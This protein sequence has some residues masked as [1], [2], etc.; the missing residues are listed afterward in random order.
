M[1]DNLVHA[2]S[3]ALGGICSTIATYPLLTITIRQ[4]VKKD[5]DVKKSFIK[6]LTET[7]KE[8][9]FLD[10]YSG[11]STSIFG[12]AVTNGIYSYWYEL[13]KSNLKKV[14][15]HEAMTT[16]ES[17]LSGA[18][19]G[20]A[21][22]LTTNP[23][24]L[25]N[26]RCSAKVTLEN[27]ADPSKVKGIG[28]IEMFKKIVK[29]EGFFS[30]WNGITPALILVINPIIQYTAFEQLKN[31]TIKH[32]GKLNAL[33]IFILG[34]LGKLVAT[35]VTYPYTLIKSRMQLRQGERDDSRYTSTIDAFKKI[36]KYEGFSG[37]YKGIQSKIYQSVLAAALLFMFKDKF[38]NYVL[39][40]V[41]ISRSRRVKYVP[42]QI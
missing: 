6:I 33:D 18:V 32:K 24:W 25:I 28:G 39:R 40:I 36:V 35:T 10:L 31:L 5:N 34:A 17:M 3:G 38:Y 12:V 22:T 21:T 42:A 14:S 9:K 13:V 20:T 11:I 15:K 27:E 41:M 19:A 30:L 37:L 4:A 2:V 1:S 26:T 16:L 29:E 8:G 23:I 7:I